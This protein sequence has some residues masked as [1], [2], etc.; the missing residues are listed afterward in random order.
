MKGKMGDPFL[1]RQSSG[2]R[3]PGSPRNDQALA[4]NDEVNVRDVVSRSDCVD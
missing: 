1:Q 3:S 2:H 4:G